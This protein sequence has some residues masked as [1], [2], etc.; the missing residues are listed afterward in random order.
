MSPVVFFFF[1]FFFFSSN[2]RKYQ[3]RYCV[4]YIK[5]KTKNEVP[6]PP[7]LFVEK[8][9]AV[10]LSLSLSPEWSLVPNLHVTLLSNYDTCIIKFGAW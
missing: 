6:F 2:N 4:I 7:L 3:F 1:F 8:V 9:I 5:K 10:S